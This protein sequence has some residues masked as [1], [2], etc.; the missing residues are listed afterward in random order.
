[1]DE[2]RRY[3]SSVSSAITLAEYSEKTMLEAFMQLLRLGLVVVARDEPTGDALL[4]FVAV[5]LVVDITGKNLTKMIS[6]CSNKYRGNWTTSVIKFN[7][8]KGTS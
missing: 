1:M 4:P 7:A 5:S 2:I 8:Q 6:E 3:R